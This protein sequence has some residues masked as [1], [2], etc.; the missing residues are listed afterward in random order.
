MSKKKLGA[1]IVCILLTVLLNLY[2]VNNSDTDVSDVKLLVEAKADTEVA[3]NVYYDEAGAFSEEKTSTYTYSNVGKLEKNKYDINPDRFL[4]LDFGNQDANIE[5]TKVEI[6]CESEKIDIMHILFD[7][8]NISVTNDILNL[9]NAGNVIKIQVSEGDPYIVVDTDNDKLFD[10]LQNKVINKMRVLAIIL[11][12]IIDIMVLVGIKYI[13][14]L[15]ALPIEIYRDRKLIF[16]LAKN[17][18]RTRFAGSYLGIVW[19]FVQPVVTVLVYWFVFQVGL[20]AGRT[21]DYPFIVWFMAGLVPWFFFAEALNGGTNALMEYSYLVKKVVFKISILPIV[22]IISSIFVHLFFIGFVV[23][24][25]WCYGYHPTV[26]SIQIIYY[27]I[28]NFV[29]VLGLAYLTSAVVCFFKDLTQIINILLQV[30]MWMT[31]I[32]WDANI[33]SSKLQFIFKLNPMYYIVDGFRDSL[34]G[35]VWFWDKILWT[36]YFWIVVVVMFALGAMVF[37]KLRVHFS[38]VL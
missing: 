12:I 1:I 17:D 5:I 11:C 13:N 20:K 30:G 16:S 10:T 36:S 34:L 2:I 31:P 21:C 22:K 6:E 18:F 7:S 38:D 29:F 37:K 14:K 32:M 27:V 19:A 3:F 23:I 25:C 24:L 35:Q 33:L 26:F 4:R 9:D 15:V 28:C 8:N